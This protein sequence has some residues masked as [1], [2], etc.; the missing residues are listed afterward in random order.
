MAISG[1]P[2]HLATPCAGTEFRAFSVWKRLTWRTLA[3]KV[4]LAGIKLRIARM[5]GW[6]SL[7]I[8]G[9]VNVPAGRRPAG[10][11]GDR[12]YGEQGV[13]RIDPVA[14]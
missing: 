1:Q 3:G 14:A 2:I 7:R 5:S 12:I 10:Q 6:D 4:R 9:F 8:F 11:T 13:A